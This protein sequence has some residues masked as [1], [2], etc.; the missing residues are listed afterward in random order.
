MVGFE[1]WSSH[2]VVRHIT[3]RPLRPA[4]RHCAIENSHSVCMLQLLNLYFQ[5]LL[6]EFSAAADIFTINTDLRTTAAILTNTDA[7]LAVKQQK[8]QVDFYGPQCMY[9]YTYIHGY[10][11]YNVQHS[12][13]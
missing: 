12:Q 2:T 10:V 8:G 13:A 7:N 1:P 11:T 5:S 4:L 6:I 9:V 3:T